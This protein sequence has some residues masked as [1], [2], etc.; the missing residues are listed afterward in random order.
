MGSIIHAVI[1]Y[2]GVI[3]AECSA[4]GILGNV[5]TVSLS[6]IDKIQTGAS[7]EEGMPLT[8]GDSRA[9]YSLESLAFHILRANNCTF[10]CVADQSM[11]RERPFAFLEDI[12]GRF[13]KEF[14][15]EVASAA[16]YSLDAA[17][18]PI[19]S[20]RMKFYND[21]SSSALSRVRGQVDELRGVMIDNIEHILERGERLELL[22][23]RTD[24]FAENSV[25]FKRGASA[26]RRQAWWQNA[27]TN[28]TVAGLAVG[29]LYV[30]AAMLCGPLLKH[31]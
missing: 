26:L 5:A 29:F 22:V 14:A 17:F 1:A 24:N 10:L 7:S 28:V 3:L 6:L 27:K 25:V 18:S 4:P 12:K 19:I 2:D 8:T 11:G 30:I 9:T 23:E 16:A 13:E 31:C 21:P 15:S 20:K